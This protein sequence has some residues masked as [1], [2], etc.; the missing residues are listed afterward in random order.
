MITVLNLSEFFGAVLKTQIL[1]NPPI[2]TI[3]L[4]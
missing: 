2:A 3:Y 4:D 1:D